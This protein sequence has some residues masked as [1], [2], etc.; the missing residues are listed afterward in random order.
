MGRSSLFARMPPPGTSR[1]ERG[2]KS[3]LRVMKFI[4]AF[5]LAWLGGNFVFGMLASGSWLP[6]VLAFILPEQAFDV[7]VLVLVWIARII[8]FAFLMEWA[9]ENKAQRPIKPHP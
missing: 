4:V 1:A 7:L 9:F 3:M 6:Y 8:I 2:E 5:P